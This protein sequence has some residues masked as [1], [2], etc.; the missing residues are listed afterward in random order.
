[1]DECS[2]CNLASLSIPKFVRR[3]PYEER[4]YVDYE[5]MHGVVK[6]MVRN[7]NKVIDNNYYPIKEAMVSNLR[8]R[9]IGVG[10]Q[11][12]ADALFMM[13]VPFES[14]EAKKIN[15]EIFETIYHAAVEASV[16]L[17]AESG[18]YETYE[19]SPASQGTLQFDM[20]GVQPSA[21]YDWDSL[22]QK[23]LESGLRNSLLVAP[24]PTASTA[25]ILG[26]NEGFEPIQT[27]MFVR[28]TLAGEFLVINK[29]LVQDLQKLG[30]WTKAIKDSIVKNKGSVQAV[31]EIPDDIK[32]LYK[33][34]YEIKQRAIIDM[35]ADRGPFICQ[36]Q[37][38]NLFLERPRFD[39]MTSMLFYGWKKGLKTGQ[40]YLRSM[41]AAD[42]I[43]VTVM[44][45]DYKRKEEPEEGC[46]MCSS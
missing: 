41:P 17:A 35:A 24:M 46:E 15:V 14:A 12:F 39:A 43:A 23:M 6:V 8:H 22:K 18:P 16:E 4:P 9:P 20:W 32:A 19:G 42:P 25:Q 34:A 13:R 38:L 5:E 31:R 26:N 10:V 28:K 30:L 44:R 29:Y 37:S 40:Y 21:M 1:M 2:V 45:N 3:G 7:L 33:T 27:N 11:G 36:S